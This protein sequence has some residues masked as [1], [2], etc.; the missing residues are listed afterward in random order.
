MTVFFRKSM[1]AEMEIL[2]QF[3]LG[4]IVTKLKEDLFL[5]DQHAAD[6]K[7]NFEMLQQHTVLQAQ[8]LITWVHPSFRARSAPL[9][10]KQLVPAAV[11]RHAYM[12]ACIDTCTTHVHTFHIMIITAPLIE[13]LLHGE[14][15][16]E[17]IHLIQVITP[18]SSCCH[19]CSQ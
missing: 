9:Q 12:W 7:Y 13:S 3:N 1:F 17:C 11:C 18:G 14:L 6:E 4:F 16:R 8:R 10:M 5:V 15:L 19:C 2:G